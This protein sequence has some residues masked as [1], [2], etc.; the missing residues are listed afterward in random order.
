MSSDAYLEPTF[1]W[2]TPDGVGHC[3]NDWSADDANEPNGQNYESDEDALQACNTYMSTLL[4]STDDASLATFGPV[5][6]CKSVNP[7]AATA[8]DCCGI[9]SYADNQPTAYI[10]NT[11]RGMRAALD[12]N[13]GTKK[14]TAPDTSPQSNG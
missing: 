2:C 5:A 13:C 12:T 3:C 1:G 9:Q 14:P 11:N 8:G 4:I 7:P 10:R 6:C